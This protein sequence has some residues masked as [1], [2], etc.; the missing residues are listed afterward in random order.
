M[1]RETAC[2]TVEDRRQVDQEMVGQFGGLSDKQT[3]QA[4]A[5]IGQRLDPGQYFLKTNKLRMLMYKPVPESR[6]RLYTTK[7]AEVLALQQEQRRTGE[8]EKRR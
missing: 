2:L 1:A 3:A 6:H 7:P 5:R 4:A 8:E